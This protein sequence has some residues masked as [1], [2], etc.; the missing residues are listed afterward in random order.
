M[1]RDRRFARLTIKLFLVMAIGVPLCMGCTAK[2]ALLVGGEGQIEPQMVASV[3]TTQGEQGTKVVIQSSRP[4]SYSLSNHGEPPRVLVEIPGAQFPFSQQHV[5]LMQVNKG[6]VRT[7]A[8]EERTDQARVEIALEQLVNY[9]IQREADRLV[10]SFKNPMTVSQSPERWAQLPQ[11]PATRVGQEWSSAPIAAPP[12]STA[13][14]RDATSREPAQELKRPAGDTSRE[15]PERLARLPKEPTALVQESGPSNPLEQVIGGTDVLEI[16]VYQEKDL[17]GMFRVSAD[18][19][20]AFPMVGNVRVAGLTPPQAQEKLEALL[21]QG[22]LKRPQV[23]VT[24]KEYHSKWVA[25]LG[26]VNKPGSYQLLGGRTTLLE[27]LSMAEGVSPREEGSKSLILVRPNENGETKS[28]T[29]DLDRLLKEGDA[30]QNIHVEPNDTIYV[31]KAETVVVYGEVQKPGTYVLEGK[32]TTMLELLKAGGL[33]KF[34]A[35]NRTRLIRVVDGK[36]KSIQVRVGDI[37]KGE[38]T[39]DVMLQ[40]GDAMVIPESYF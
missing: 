40:A 3:E 5:R 22:Y 13:T 38:K 14:G 31:S 24:M 9:E 25:V 28:I 39:R 11:E 10:L 16:T 20:I 2:P 32:E 23:L 21:R 35:P 12:P 26:A 34:A 37:I 17:S 19:A 30:S 29:I 15:S 6:V 4:F 27:L 7:I 8:L 1:R 18:G 33:T 36:E